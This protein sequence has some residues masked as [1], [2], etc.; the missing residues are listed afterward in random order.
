MMPRDVMSHEPGEN[1]DTDAH[2]SPIHAP[3]RQI[4]RTH[5]D[6]IH[7]ASEAG[8]YYQSHVDNQKSEETQHGQEMEGARRL[9]PTENPRVPWE[10]VH[11]GGRHGNPGR[12]R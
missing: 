3:R 9:S 4:I 5:H 1:D 12:H 7:V 11:H 10:M 6:V 2:K 8:H